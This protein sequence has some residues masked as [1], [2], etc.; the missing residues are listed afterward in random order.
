MSQALHAPG[1]FIG[2]KAFRVFQPS[3][4]QRHGAVENIIK[5]EIQFPAVIRREFFLPFVQDT[6][7]DDVL[8]AAEN[9]GDLR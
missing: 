2:G 5:Q 6:V 4:H 1:K 9:L 3:H 8:Q 7:A